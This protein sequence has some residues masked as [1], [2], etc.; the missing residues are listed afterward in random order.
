MHP[1]IDPVIRPEVDQIF[2]F[3][4]S[5]LMNT[6]QALQLLRQKFGNHPH[7]KR[8]ERLLKIQFGN[9]SKDAQMITAGLKS[10]TDE[11]EYAVGDQRA[12]CLFRIASAHL[13][14]G[15]LAKQGE[16]YP[17]ENEHYVTA[18]RRFRECI[19]ADSKSPSAEPLLDY[20]VCLSRFGRML[21]GIKLLRRAVS[22]QPWHPVARLALANGL[23][24]LA[25]ATRDQLLFP[26]ALFHLQSID[27]SRFRNPT[28]RTE[29]SAA[30]LEIQEIISKFPPDCFLIPTYV[31]NQYE[32][33]SQR[34]GL[35]LGSAQ[36]EYGDTVKLRLVYLLG[37]RMNVYKLTRFLN[38]IKQSFCTAR[39][40]AYEMFA[41]SDDQGE[42]AKTPYTDLSDGA[43]YGTH[44]G[45]LRL[46][47]ESALNTLDKIGGFLNEYLRLAIPDKVYFTSKQLWKTK[48][49]G[50]VLRPEIKSSMLLVALYDLNREF[51]LNGML[52]DVKAHRD[53]STHRYLVVHAT[54]D[55]TWN[56][57]IDDSASHI[58]LRGLFTETFDLLRIVRSAIIYTVAYVNQEGYKKSIGQNLQFKELP[59]HRLP[60]LG[61]GDSSY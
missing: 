61:L 9:L 46:A 59:W 31:P 29:A 7:W 38:D 45:K 20:A 50:G 21:E 1:I 14:L 15:D 47:Q 41:V 42:Q 55:K 3:V 52:S 53:A 24:N 32:Q 49:T 12:S 43:T 58:G 13:S 22:I 36:H 57:A 16:E 48:V 17:I 11:L 6:N 44:I 19:L 4:A 18:K 25:R 51:S 56:K 27:F 34:E 28:A 23:T 2:G 5:N 37:E 54:Q 33:F 40:L 60:P 35:F 26:E 30:K 39:L 10:S 8:M